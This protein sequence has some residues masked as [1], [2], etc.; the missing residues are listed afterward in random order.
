MQENS[1]LLG[2]SVIFR[3]GGSLRTTIP[4][5]VAAALRLDSEDSALWISAGGFVVFAPSDG[6]LNT[7]R[8]DTALLEFLGEQNKAPALKSKRV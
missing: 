5:K 6:L 4:K 2:S 1:R 8:L 3:Q 7:E